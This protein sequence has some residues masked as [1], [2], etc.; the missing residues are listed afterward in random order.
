MLTKSDGVIEFLLAAL[1]RP[2]EF[3][4][5]KASS[6]DRAGENGAIVEKN[7]NNSYEEGNMPRLHIVKPAYLKNGP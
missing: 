1:K 5:M 6:V 3:A 4:N 7:G 2:L